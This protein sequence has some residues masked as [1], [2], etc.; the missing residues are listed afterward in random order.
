MHNGDIKE[1]SI[2]P[3]A[4]S[5][6]NRG[7]RWFAF[8][9]GKDVSGYFAIGK[10]SDHQASIHLNWCRFNARSF[11]NALC[12]FDSYL[13]PELKKMGMTSVIATKTYNSRAS[14]AWVKLVKRFG[15]P[16]PSV[17]L[18]SERKI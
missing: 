15:F 13:V 12:L 14:E 1:L 16:E 9:T 10:V 11:K 7:H 8:Y 5:H 6:L 17:V 2:R 18:V 3:E 4:F